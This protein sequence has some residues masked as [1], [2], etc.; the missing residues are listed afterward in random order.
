[1]Q[2][3][4]VFLPKQPK[5]ELID[6]Y[7]LDP[8]EQMWRPPQIPLRL[9]QLQRTSKTLDDI[10]NK[11]YR[12]Q[13]EYAQ[14]IAWIKREWDR[15]L[16]GYWLFINGKATYMDGWH[17]FYCGYWNLDIG[18]PEY[19]YRDYLF[20]H[21]ARFCYTDT[22][23]PDGTDMERRL[24]YGFNYPKH[25]REGATYKAE[26]INYEIVSRTRSVHGGIQSMDGDSAKDAFLDKLVNPWQ[27]LPFFFKPKYTGSTA[28]KSVLM[29]D[30][31]SI[32]VTTKGGLANVD[33]GLQSKITYAT[34][35]ARGFYDGK[36]LIFYHDDE[37]GKCFGYGTKLLMYDGSEKEI[38]DVV[39]GDVLMG[40]D[41]TPR[42]V[43]ELIRGTDQLY[44]IKPN[45]GDE[46]ICNKEHIL[47]LR[48]CADHMF[49][50]N[51]KHGQWVNMSVETFL[52]L[53]Y[54]Q[55]R[56][57]KLIHAGV[58]YPEV[59]HEL[60]PY[61]LGVWLGDG[62]HN[63][64]T[65]YN[66]D[67]EII[68][69][70]KQYAKEN[71][72]T[73]KKNGI[74]HYISTSNCRKLIATK[75]EK[76]EFKSKIDV[77]NF[78]KTSPETLNDKFKR[79]TK[80]N[81]YD[82]FIEEYHYNKFYNDLKNL[83]LINNKHIPNEYLIDSKKN[84]L[85]LLAG[86][87][88]TD[89]SRRKGRNIFEITQV[90]KELAYQ[91]VTLVRGLGFKA[92]LK[93]KSSSMKRSD[94]TYYHGICYRIS[95]YGNNL[96]EIPVRVKRKKIKNDKINKNKNPLH[97]GFKIEPVDYGNYF[98]VNTTG[99]RLFLLTDHTIVHNCKE[100]NVYARHMVVK[101]CLSQAN[102]RLIH[103]FTIKTSTVGEMS[104]KG[105]DEFYKLCKDSMYEQRNENG[106]TI[107]G[108]YNLFIPAYVCLDGF[109]DIFGNPII[110][111]PTDED[112]WKIP[113]PTR[114]VH[115]ELIGA[116]RYLENTREAYLK[117]E[118]FDS[119]ANLEEEIRL[120]P[121]SFDECFITA[122]SSS[123]LPMQKIMKRIKELQFVSNA[124][125]G[126]EVGDFKW[127]HNKQDGVVVFEKNKTGKFRVSHLPVLNNQKQ[128]SSIWDLT[129]MVNTFKPPDD[130]LFV[131]SADP[132]QFLKTEGNR[133]SNGAGAVFMLRDERIDP[134]EKHVDLWET[135]RT[136]CTYV[137]RPKDP[138]DFA[139]D[140][141]MMCVYFGAFMFPEI[142]IDLI[143]KHFRRRGYLGYLLYAHDPSG[144]KRNTPG[145]YNKGSIPQDLFNAHKRYLENHSQREKHIEVLQ[146][147]KLIKG[148]EDLTNRDLF[149]AVGGAYLGADQ[150][151]YTPFRAFEK[152]KVSIKDFFN[153]KS[154]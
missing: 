54:Q 116:K 30:E 2:T 61:L 51:N 135:Y 11:L 147:C 120:A 128:K 106:E 71:N 67:V 19:R 153:T 76:T 66:I 28:P 24:C 94:G 102:G 118:S 136:V 108:L 64:S 3:I 109:V 73:Y 55:Q 122:G 17:Y 83:N 70:L 34:T 14:E 134:D 48:M 101:K 59:K 141:L 9:Q 60:P 90:R 35:A 87:I 107:T 12:N 18:L 125:L 27:K 81:G 121:M 149:V 95:I 145:F 45:Y 126:I 53:S 92:I 104:S 26:C 89:G 123:G 124:E 132:Y 52:S 143:W 40:N 146:E 99:N 98:G 46:W 140:M 79:K 32:N 29:F 44:K 25:R 85:E 119:Q 112:L 42:Y 86:L 62:S 1:M 150:M 103:G 80:Y 138:D 21:F 152:K 6:G 131:A 50:K 5:E 100:E 16:N 78:F 97:T 82:I 23:L 139:E 117:E 65:T 37:T 15:R 148:V 105:G 77:S 151:L 75:K 69:Y 63:K 114:N 56:N 13:K 111:D 127:M 41:S 84:R 68:D 137:N 39:V 31:P 58:E 74:N 57:L 144:K 36:K 38:Q 110:E 33:I 72:L 133:L 47:T 20:F 49:Y 113:Y 7:G 130:T 22:K 4:R 10:Q 43:T 142:N 129:G 115:G 93:E 154:Y 96:Y 91:I 88:D 8:K